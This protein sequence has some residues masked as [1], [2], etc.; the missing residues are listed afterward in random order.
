[1]SNNKAKG[2]D[3]SKVKPEFVKQVE[4][5]IAEG[6]RHRYSASGVYAVH[7]AAY[8]LKETPQTCSSCL[9]AR[10]NKL[11]DWMKGYKE[12]QKKSNGTSYKAIVDG[13][14]SLI[15]LQDDG[16]AIDKD[17]KGVKPGKYPVIEGG[18]IIVSVGSKGRYEEPEPVQPVTHKL[19]DGRT[20]FVDADNKATFQDVEGKP[21][22][23]APG[24]YAIEGSTQFV[25]IGLTSD[26]VGIVDT[27][28]YTID[29]EEGGV[30]ELNPITGAATIDGNPAPEGD[31]FL[32]GREPET[33]AVLIVGPNGVAVK[34][35][36]DIFIVEDVKEE[37][38]TTGGTAE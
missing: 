35:E 26:F 3:Y 4:K 23:V 1:M 14:E 12:Y 13:I 10:V 37:K 27:V 11:R 25:R 8:G 36:G 17:G 32:Q 29:G 20:L 6:D 34:Q 15:I 2:P 38:P 19:A 5:V 16:K 28:T 30:I 21:F 18:T 7:N 24:E 33:L 9:R 31:Y 22:A